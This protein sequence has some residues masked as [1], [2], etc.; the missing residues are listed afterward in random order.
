MAVTH[1]HVRNGSM[2]DI[3]KKEK[4]VTLAD[5]VVLQIRDAIKQGKLKPGERII[6]ATVAQEISISRVTV[7]EALRHLEKEGLI[8]TTPYKGAVVTALTDKA[9]EEIFELRMVLEEL[10]IRTVIRKL[11]AKKISTL[12][13]MVEKMK[14]VAE[15]GKAEAVIDADLSFHRTICELSEN[16]RLLKAWLDLSNQLRAFIAAEG[17]LYPNAPPEETLPSHFPVVDAIKARDAD[18]A[19]DIMK[20]LITFGYQNALKYRQGKT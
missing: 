20:D 1:P 13:S 3:F 14:T 19:S 18:R 2:K 6:E 4:R 11:T 17:R 16:Q 7:R 15:E 8:S 12:D 9:L 5:R 10:A